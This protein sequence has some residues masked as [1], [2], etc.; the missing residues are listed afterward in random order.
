MSFG[1]SSMSFGTIGRIRRTSLTILEDEPDDPNDDPQND[2]DG[3][4]D[5]YL[6]RRRSWNSFPSSFTPLAEKRVWLPRSTPPY[7]LVMKTCAAN[8]TKSP[9]TGSPESPVIEFVVTTVN[10]VTMNR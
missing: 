10:M 7:I 5:E 2:L 1:T 6:A 4:L 3:L 8:A 9:S